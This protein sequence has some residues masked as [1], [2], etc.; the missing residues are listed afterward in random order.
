MG[1]GSD[2]SRGLLLPDRKNRK[3]RLQGLNKQNSW[4]FLR[5]M[6]VPPSLGRLFNIFSC[7]LCLFESQMVILNFEAAGDWN[8]ACCHSN[9]KMCTTW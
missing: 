1:V 6:P 8:R 7:I 3:G 5:H 9:I 4:S 2:C